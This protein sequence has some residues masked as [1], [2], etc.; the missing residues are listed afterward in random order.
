[1]FANTITITIAT[2]QDRILQRINQDSYGSEYQYSDAV[3]SCNLKI[4]HSSDKKD[5]NGLVMKRHNV[6]FERIVYP[7]PTSLMKSQTFTA[8]LRGD[9]YSDPATVAGVAKG[10]EAWLQSTTVNADLAVGVN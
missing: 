1:M 4:R 6:F 3:E 7:T 8:T 10:V 5:A 9:T 2:G